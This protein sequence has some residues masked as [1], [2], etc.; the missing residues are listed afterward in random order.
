MSS[1]PQL[2]DPRF[3]KQLKRLEHFNQFISEIAIAVVARNEEFE[4]VWNAANRVYDRYCSSKVRFM[5]RSDWDE[6]R[7]T[8]LSA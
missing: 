4:S 1:I 2:E 6:S 8:A 5:A 3:T 7:N